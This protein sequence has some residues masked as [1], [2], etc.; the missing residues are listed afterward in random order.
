MQIRIEPLTEDL[1]PAAR[2]F[3][4]RLG[5]DAPFFLPETVPSLQSPTRLVS[6]IIS[7]NHYVAMDDSEA[8]GGFLLMDQPAWI[9]GEVRRASNYQSVL[10]ESV[11]DKRFGSVSVL[12]LKHIEQ[13]SPYAFILGM[14][15]AQ[16][17]LPRLL[18][19]SGWTLRPVPFLFRVQNVRNFLREMSAFRLKGYPRIAAR[20]ASLSGAGWVAI[21]LLQ[22]RVLGRIGSS[23]GLT[24]DRMT[25]W[26]PWADEIWE[27]YRNQCSFAVV[28]DRT[29]LDLLYPLVEKRLV[30]YLVSKGS[31]PI[32]WTAWLNTP[33]RNDAYFGNL[34]VVTVL[35]C[36]AVPEF[37]ESFARLITGHLEDSGADLVITNQ[38]HCIW[39]SAFRKAGFLSAASNYLL[40]TS[41][42]L[43][44]AILAAGGER[45]VH[46][47]RG[48][49]DGRIHL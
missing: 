23:L 16:N 34:R 19:A 13:R 43:S 48:D 33:M 12:M 40:A 18:K 49:G 46:L 26:G 17:P 38:A 22:A 41:K 36:V 47:T 4:A 9:N 28:R 30:V 39:T 21:R 8:R 20:T 37:A 29:T 31:S 32:G 10:S 11:R 5:P 35:D 44:A 2:A 7:W 1:L 24:V 3:N 27:R 25:S 45:R 15:G 14:G 6:P 42:G